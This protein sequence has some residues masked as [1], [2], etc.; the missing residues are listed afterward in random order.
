MCE[1]LAAVRCWLP[2]HNPVRWMQGNTGVVRVSLKPRDW[3]PHETAELAALCAEKRIPYATV[4][5]L[6]AKW[7]RSFRSLT[8][9]AT[10]IRHGI[11]KRNRPS[12][13]VVPET[14]KHRKC[15]CCER[16]F[17][18]LSPFITRCDGCKTQMA[19]ST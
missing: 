19:W 6:A 18:A 12:R 13:A 9:K 8:N 1:V 10:R 11:P 3:T 16:T 14:V 5:F 17:G 4:R 15:A 7:G 2:F